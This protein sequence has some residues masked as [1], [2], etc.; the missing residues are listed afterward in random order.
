MGGPPRAAVAAAPLKSTQRFP[1]TAIATFAAVGLFVY[2]VW[3]WLAAAKPVGAAVLVG[4]ILLL[5]TI[6][7]AMRANRT[8]PDFDLGGLLLLGLVMRFGFAYYRFTHAA[9]ANV[10][11]QEGIRLADGYRNFDF[12]APTG[13][14][15]PGTG[16]MRAIS[17]GVHVLVYDDFFATFLIMTWLSLLGCW[18]LYRA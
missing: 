2:Y 14:E 18:F 5:I 7:V 12:S 16:A 13:A 11:H 3:L 4:P 15:V 10:Y 6:P 1:W 9:D 8:T 17:G